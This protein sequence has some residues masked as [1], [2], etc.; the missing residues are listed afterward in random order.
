M[1]PISVSFDGA[2]AFV[3]VNNPPVNAT[4]TSVRA[5]LLAAVAACDAQPLRA[6]IFFGSGKTFV[7][8]GNMA[9]FDA[10]PV[11]P[12]LPD[13]VQAI[14]ASKAPW[15]AAMHGTVLGGG[16]ELA[17]GCTYRVALPG[18]KFGLPE[19]LV[20]LVPGAGGTQRLPRL[21]SVSAA[22]EMVSTG[23]PQD[24]ATFLALGGLDAII[25][26]TSAQEA[27]IAF[28]AQLPETRPMPVS[29]RDC[30]GAGVDWPTLRTDI[31]RKFKGQLA[32][33]E[34]CDLIETAS[35][36][37]FVQG[38]LQERARHLALRQSVQSKALRHAFFAERSVAKSEILRDAAPRKL[39]RVV[40]VGG[41]LMGA[42][43]AFACL[44]SGLRVSVI[45][46]TDAAV[47]AGLARVHG[48][49]DGA[50]VRAKASA[51]DATQWRA[52]LDGGSNYALAVGA[53][54]VIEAVF[55][56]LTV[57]QSVFKALADVVDPETIFATNTS[58]L[59]PRD[60]MRDVVNP[61]R[62]IGLHFFSPAH[63]MKLLEVVRLP[64]T[65]AEVL[66]TGVGLGKR[67]RKIPVL[68]GICDGF[69]GNRILVA[70]R[71]QADYFLIDG[72][73]PAQIDRAMRAF[74]FPMGP[75]ELQDLTGLQIAW[76]NRKRLAIR[77]PTAER[78]VHIADA[79]CEMGRF[80][81]RGGA[82]WYRYDDGSR[83]PLHDLA[84][85]QIIA[86]QAAKSGVV[87]RGI[88]EAEITAGILAA[89]VN[90][91]AQIVEEGIAADPRDVDM[92]MIHGYGFPR[93][94]GGPMHYADHTGLEQVGTDMA[95]IA[96]QSPNSWAIS[97]LLSVPSN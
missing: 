47:A 7:A 54:M 59:D 81:R 13:V 67:L 69:I 75:Y 57:K 53:E 51:A 24:A 73:S 55:E 39:T 62:C 32:P 78:Y 11:L 43:I 90:E 48:L 64:E 80:G 16:L 89:I 41:G 34:A 52:A 26:A 38:Q 94:R 22:L 58:Y 44:S 91:G 33:L 86:E 10:Q 28:A 65:S 2:L 88:S 84:V 83:A 85:D 18:T 9:E 71:R 61:S 20:G 46:Q 45:E 31:A 42:G 76:A 25:D 50:V 17:L 36:I 19:V 29:L 95:Q 15:I 1:S 97:K 8:G 6:V 14:E 56:D 68:A 3:C 87:R 70:Y 72:A 27:G 79:L 77:R 4:A 21:I 23:A 12:D 60:I 96:R 5:G 30:Q 63:V 66:A 74:G 40:V 92:V 37:S 49:I 35:K 93:W 82:G